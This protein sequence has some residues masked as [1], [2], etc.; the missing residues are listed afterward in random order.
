MARVK[1]RE[2]FVP[3][4]NEDVHAAV[5]LVMEMRR[6]LCG[7]MVSQALFVAAELQVPDLL[8]DG[9]KGADELAEQTTCHAPSLRRLLRALAAFRIFLEREDGSFELTPLGATLRSDV[10]HSARATAIMFG[11]EHARSW[12]ELVHSVRTGETA[13][14]HIYGMGLFDYAAKHPRMAE[15]FNRVMTQ[16]STFMASDI[17]DSFD[18]APYR[19]IVDVGGGHGQLLASI[20]KTN[21]AGNGILFDL[22]QAV[23]EAGSLIEAEGVADRCE[24]A[25]GNFFERV[26]KGGDLYI[27]KSI[28]HDWDYEHSV[29]IL[30]NCRRAMNAGGTLLVIE[31]VMP[32]RVIPDPELEW[33]A[34]MDLNMLVVAGGRERT[35]SEYRQLFEAAGFS[36]T[37]MESMLIGMVLIRGAPA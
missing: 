1:N 9:P 26:P 25:A 33:T 31:R 23:E 29:K 12:V 14:D 10:P 15:I 16:S 20:L 36:L 13:F 32:D 30:T 22:P 21:V 2:S 8:A 19:T 35:E 27:L 5:D 17:V 18:F 28:I 4:T 24:L 6:L 37:R 34:L 11:A 7:H 3:D